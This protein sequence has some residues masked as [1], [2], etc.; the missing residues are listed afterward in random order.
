M[1][2]EISLT[3]R[4]LPVGGIKE[5]II[6]VSGF[7][8]HKIKKRTAQRITVAIGLSALLPSA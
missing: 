2:G 3:G 5:K 7:D 6:A 1:T 8:G 4:I